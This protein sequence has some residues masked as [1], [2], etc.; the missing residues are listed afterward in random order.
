MKNILLTTVA[1][2]A[3]SMAAFSANAADT[4]TLDPTHTNIVWQ[5][6]HFGFSN[7]SGKLSNPDNSLLEQIKTFVL[8][9]KLS[10]L[11]I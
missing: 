1:L 9:G 10:I 2:S 3:I 11:V 8:I 5:A 6:N 4:Y 7:P